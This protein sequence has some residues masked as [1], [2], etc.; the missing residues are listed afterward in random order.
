MNDVTQR[1]QFIAN[2]LK[3]YDKHIEVF[4][5]FSS[6]C[7]LFSSMRDPIQFLVIQEITYPVILFVLDVLFVGQYKFFWTFIQWPIFVF[8]FLFLLNSRVITDPNGFQMCRNYTYSISQFK[9]FSW[10]SRSNK[11][12]KNTEYSNDS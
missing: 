5:F 3:V 1:S 8:L 6:N 4:L 7:N 10:I 11:W 2:S 12:I 9:F